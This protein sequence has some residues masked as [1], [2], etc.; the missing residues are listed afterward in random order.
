MT[1]LLGGEMVEYPHWKNYFDI[2]IVAA[3]KPAF[4]QEQRPLMERDGATLRPAAFPL[5]RGKV[6]EG[7]NLG[8]LERALGVPSDEVLYDGYHIYGDILMSKK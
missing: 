2:V 7:G 1:Y 5:E 3:T 6:Y 4:F 8:D